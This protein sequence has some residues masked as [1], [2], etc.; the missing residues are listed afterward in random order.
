MDF[1]LPSHV[2]TQSV[3]WFTN[4][5]ITPI[6]IGHFT[7]SFQESICWPRAFSLQCECLPVVNIEKTTFE[8]RHIFIQYWDICGFSSGE[9]T[10]EVW[11][12]FYKFRTFE[13]HQ[14]DCF[15]NHQ[16]A[17][18]TAYQKAEFLLHFGKGGKF[19]KQPV[20]FWKFMLR[21][22]TVHWSIWTIFGIVFRY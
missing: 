14:A 12:S 4:C 11:Y 22:C 5:M 10:R 16:C 9:S 19:S 7:W 1:L 21:G 20:S 3:R 18:V 6:L 8:I 17:R 15:S 13:T 2:M